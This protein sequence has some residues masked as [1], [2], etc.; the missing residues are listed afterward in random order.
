M[1]LKHTDLLEGLDNVSLDTLG[2]VA[3]VA[4][5]GSSSVLGS[6]QLGERTDTD[7][8]S[9]VDVSGDRSWG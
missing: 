7:V 8:L 2:R 3:V 9:E 5:S 6:V 1:G 4:W